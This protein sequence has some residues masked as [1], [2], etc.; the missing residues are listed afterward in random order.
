M[1]TMSC[2]GTVL[3]PFLPYVSA[4]P[5]LELFILQHPRTR[6]PSQSR[7]TPWAMCRRSITSSAPDLTLPPSQNSCYQNLCRPHTGHARPALV[8]SQQW[9]WTQLQL[10]PRF[11]SR[12]GS[13][14][15][16]ICNA[17]PIGRNVYVCLLHTMSKGYTG[18]FRL[19][20]RR[21]R[22]ILQRFYAIPWW[23]AVLKS[24]HLRRTVLKLQ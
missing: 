1:R 14:I 13:L 21:Q 8:T 3:F 20:A 11:H 17:K 16:N 12:S 15:Y 5:L 2:L 24:P 7:T 23:F 22:V 6:V 4:V 19:Y 10:P 9:P 18:M